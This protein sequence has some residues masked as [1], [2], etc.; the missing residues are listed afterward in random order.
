[1]AA[2]SPLEA[3]IAKFHNGEQW[4]LVV[5]MRDIAE[6]KK[7]EDELTRRSTHDSLTGLPN[8]VLIRERLGQCLAAFAA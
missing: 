5:T 2:F 6:R 4:L 3:S 8:R 1:M 7:A